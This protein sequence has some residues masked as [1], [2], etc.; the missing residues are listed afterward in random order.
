LINVL[1]LV[2]LSLHDLIRTMSCAEETQCGK[3][4]NVT[5]AK[6]VM[7]S[8]VSVCLSVNKITQNY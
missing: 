6:E 8:P 1:I 7:F 2:A 3:V 4:N 5:S